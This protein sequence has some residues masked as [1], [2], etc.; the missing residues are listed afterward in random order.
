MSLLLSQVHDIDT[1][2]RIASKTISVG[3]FN[4]IAFPEYNGHLPPP[5]REP[6]Y[7]KVF[8]TQR[9]VPEWSFLQSFGEQFP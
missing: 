3:K 9:C 2:V 4:K 1:Y 6:L 5:F 7:D 8:G